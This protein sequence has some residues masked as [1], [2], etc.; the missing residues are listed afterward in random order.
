MSNTTNNRQVQKTSSPGTFQSGVFYNNLG[1]GTTPGNPIV[2]NYTAQDPNFAQENNHGQ[3][4]RSLER[5]VVHT[6]KS[7]MPQKVQAQSIYIQPTPLIN[8]QSNFFYFLD[9]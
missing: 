5:R 2:K 9:F 6:T 8:N 7:P 4:R 1:K 3:S